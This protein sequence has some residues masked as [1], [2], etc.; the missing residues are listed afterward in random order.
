M[1]KKFKDIK[2]SLTEMRMKGNPRGQDTGFN[3]LDRIYSIKQGSFTFI[4]APPHHGKSEFAFELLFNQAEKYGKRSVVYSPET[5]SVED[6]YAEFIHKYTGKPFYKSIPGSVDD[7]EFHNAIH[8]ID[9]MFTIIDS[10]EKSY[11]L[12]DLTKLV[13]NEDII[14]ADPYNEILHDMSKYGGRQDL[15]IEDFAGDIRR[16]CKKNKKHIMLTL[17]P[18]NQMK[19]EDKDMNGKKIRYYPMPTAREA[20]GGQALFRKAMTWINLWRPQIGLANEIGMPYID[21]EVLVMIEKAKPKGVAV[22]GIES[23]FFDWKKNRYYEDISG[24]SKY[25]F[26]H[27]KNEALQNDVN[28]FIQPNF[29]FEN[30]EF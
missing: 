4:L 29:N 20:A 11:S 26:E 22:R 19:V 10:D 15:Y 21:N 17:H 8:Y 9:E 18:A 27:E 2:D 1:I 6:I 24:K 16:Y 3:S 30:P 7:K 5:G 23:L 14:L 28:Q 12:N 13:T 25:A